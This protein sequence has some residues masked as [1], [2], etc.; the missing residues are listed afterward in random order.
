M[1]GKYLK[2]RTPRKHRGL[3]ILLILLLLT[4]GGIETTMAKY[5]Q[6]STGKILVEAPEFYFTSAYLTAD[7]PTYELNADTTQVEFTLRNSA[8]ELRYS[9]VDIH[10]AVALKKSPE[11]ASGKLTVPSDSLLGGSVQSTPDI[12]LSEM[13]PGVT[14]TVTATGTVAGTTDYSQTISATFTVADNDKNLYMNVAESSG[15]YYLLTVWSRNISGTL[16]ITFPA[17][18]VPDN[19]NSDMASVFNKDTGDN[20][21]TVANFGTYSS[22]TYRFF[23]TPTT[24]QFAVSIGKH[25][26]TAKA[27]PQ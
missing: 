12:I 1:A 10:Y 4:S 8:D 22:Q 21:F 26:A 13:A 17:G 6:K 19:T 23:G 5:I 11:N 9:D 27:L 14:Y 18:L 3:L 2:K 16:S 25:Q 15:G 24:G 7:N 20:S